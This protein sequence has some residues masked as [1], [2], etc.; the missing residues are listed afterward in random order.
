MHVVVGLALAAIAFL[1]PLRQSQAAG[2]AVCDTYVKEAVAKAR[3]MRSFGCGYD[4]ND[5]RW[6]TDRKSHAQW[7]RASPEDAVAKETAYRRGEMK[8]CQ[9]CRAYAE[10]AAEAAAESDKLKCGFSGTRWNVH[11]DTHFSWCMALRDNESAAG[12]DVAATYK[13]ITTKIQNVTHPEAFERR[14]QIVKCKV[15]GA[16]PPEAPPKP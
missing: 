2:T 7:C 11:P 6:T 12:F 14:L 1:I 15:S 5:L 3:G 10:I 9:S 13:S 8:L 4:L 16:N